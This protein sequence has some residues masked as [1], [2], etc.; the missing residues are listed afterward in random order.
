MRR[1]AE[2]LC[3]MLTASSASAGLVD[4]TTQPSAVV[5]GGLFEQAGFRSSGTGTMSP[6]VRIQ[7]SGVEQGYNTSGRP[8]PFDEVTALNYMHDLTLGDVPIRNVEGV[9]YF[10]LWL[11]INQS[12]NASASLLSLDALQIYTSNVPSQTT[13]NVATLGALRYDLDESEDNWILLD[14][15]LSSGSGQGDMRALIPVVAF[16]NELPS[17]YVYVYSAFG[18]HN[19]ANSGVEEWAVE[20]AVPAPG[21]AGVLAA[22]LGLFTRRRRAGRGR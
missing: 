13:T 11:D 2:L 18:V 8:V 17:T 15:G 1:A 7:K 10:E 19:A 6:F 20:T 22:G 3:V 4:L 14:A 16:Q 5:S 9:L 21:G 12:G